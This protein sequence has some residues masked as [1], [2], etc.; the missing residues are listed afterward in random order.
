MPEDEV[1]RVEAAY[2]GNYRRLAQIKRQY[3]PQNLF[4]LN[5]NVKP[6]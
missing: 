1:D 5:Q 6:L 2:G 3:D 4:R